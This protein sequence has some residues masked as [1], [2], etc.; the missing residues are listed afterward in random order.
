[1]AW[2]V[3]KLGYP[4]TW[5]YDR[6]RPLRYSHGYMAWATKNKDTLKHSSSTG[7][8]YCDTR[9]T[10]QHGQAQNFYPLDRRDLGRIRGKILKLSALR[11]WSRD[12]NLSRRKRLRSYV[13][14]HKPRKLFA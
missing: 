1:M 5:F 8:G 3:T 10:I 9:M 11:D 6:D 2:T 13:L 7:T 4:Q 14:Q 12:R